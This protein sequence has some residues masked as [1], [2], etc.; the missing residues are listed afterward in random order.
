MILDYLRR[1][2]AIV[3]DYSHRELKE[4]LCEAEYFQVD[5][6]ISILKA[7]QTIFL[8][9]KSDFDTNGLFYF[10]GTKA[11]QQPWQNPMDL[12]AVV[13][14]ASTMNAG[15]LSIAVGRSNGVLQTKN[16]P[17]SWICVSSTASGYRLRVINTPF[18]HFV[19][20]SIHYQT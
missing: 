11:N 20:N 6:L 15:P 16:V 2:K 10:L 18:S 1:G 3:D 14:T 7:S 4:L 5:G 8:N 13:V 12:G 17:N 9:Y 19:A